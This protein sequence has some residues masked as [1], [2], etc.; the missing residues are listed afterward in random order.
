MTTY[1]KCRNLDWQ[2]LDVKGRK[3]R[4]MKRSCETIGGVVALN[5]A[6]PKH[7]QF[8]KKIPSLHVHN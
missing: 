5:C 2:H 3:T 6:M 4:E 8:K 7:L 1:Y